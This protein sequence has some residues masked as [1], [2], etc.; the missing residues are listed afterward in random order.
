MAVQFLADGRIVTANRLADTV[1]VIAP[2]GSVAKVVVGQPSRRSPAEQ[3]ELLF[4]SRALVP[5]NIAAGERSI[6]AC[7]A[8]H[9]DA[10]VDGRLHPAK[11]NRF[12][13][14]TKTVRGIGSTAPYLFL[15]E[16]PTLAA[17]SQNLVSTHA[18]GAERG[19]GYDQ[20]SVR[21]PLWQGHRFGSQLL[22][23]AQVRS[24]MTAYL[25]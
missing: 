20:Y 7:S 8:C 13:S 16:V 21:L 14:M 23:P 4:F 22:S 19:V 18:Q 9:D 17:F 25:Q 5:H 10:H 12:Y 24:A 6:Y 1:S 15:G 2:D 3:G 11:R